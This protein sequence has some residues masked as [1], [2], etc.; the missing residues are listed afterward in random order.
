MVVFSAQITVGLPSNSLVSRQP[1]LRANLVIPGLNPGEGK[2][3]KQ[4]G[5]LTLTGTLLCHT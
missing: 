5:H 2:S 1:V 4:G 3:R